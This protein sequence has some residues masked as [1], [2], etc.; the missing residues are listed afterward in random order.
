MRGCANSSSIHRSFYVLATEYRGRDIHFLRPQPR[1]LRLRH[2]RLSFP[3]EARLLSCPSVRG[4]GRHLYSRRL[5]TLLTGTNQSMGWLKQTSQ[6]TQNRNWVTE[7]IKASTNGNCSHVEHVEQAEYQY[8]QQSYDTAD[9]DLPSIPADTVRG[10]KHHRRLWIVIDN[11]VYD[12][13]KFAD[14]HPG[15]STVIESFSG[16]DCS[17]QFWRFH[18]KDHLREFGRPLRVGR[19][20]GVA[21]RFKEQLRF[22]GLRGL[23][24]SDE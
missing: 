1:Y 12:C 8:L 11:I 5:C 13:T 22:V 2:F 14:E 19:A 16:E 6:E 3:I 18:R 7:P 24:S 21:N 23:G 4:N 20:N 15:G 9:A 17:W 10:I